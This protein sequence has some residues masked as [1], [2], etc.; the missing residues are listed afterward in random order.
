DKINYISEEDYQNISRRSGVHKGDVL[1]AMIGTIGNPIVIEVEPDFAIKNV[2]LFKVPK[3]RDGHFLKYYLKTS[4]V[5]NKMMKE[6]KGT[7]QKFVGLGYL[8][9]FPIAIPNSN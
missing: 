6:A 8:R 5:K 9:Q 3:N 2:A 7:T 1:F 4:F